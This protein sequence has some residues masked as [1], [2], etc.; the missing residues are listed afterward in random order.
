MKKYFPVFLAKKGE[1]VALQHLSQAVKDEI[2]PVIEVLK[3][4]LEKKGKKKGQV[5]YNDYFENNL[6]THWSF[7]GNQVILDFSY[8]DNLEDKLAEIRGL[9]ESTIVNGTNAVPAIQ[10]NS[11]TGYLNLVKDIVNKYKTSVCIRVSNESGGFLD[12][13]NQIGALA[14]K[15]GV[16]ISN[17]ILLVDMGQVDQKNYNTMASLAGMTI[18]QLGAISEYQDIV[19][20]ASSFPENLSD[21]D[22][23][24]EPHLLKRCEW[25]MWQTINKVEA[26]KGVKCGDYGTRSSRFSDA[27]FAGSI[28]LKYSTKE[29]FVIYRGKLTEDHKDGHGQY[30]TH[31]KK[32]VQSEHYSGS[33]FSWG[34]FKIEEVSQQVVSDEE[35]KTGNPTNWVQYSQ[36]HHVSLLH[37]IL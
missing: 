34:D 27:K 9:F 14:K 30:I 6:K 19:V 18:L 37:S 7:F 36:N 4:T 35:R 33:K 5:L 24:D 31:A 15:V 22:A 20:A 16:P 23:K 17:T 10:S 11:P 3:D 12:Y 29:N 8:C 32:L 28:S 2:T 13:S 1:L 21:L 26:L 25:L